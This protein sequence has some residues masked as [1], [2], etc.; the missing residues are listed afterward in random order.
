MLSKDGSIE[1]GFG[2]AIAFCGFITPLFEGGSIWQNMT[3]TGSLTVLV[4]GVVVAIYG[5]H[6]RRKS[7]RESVE[8]IRR[9]IA[10]HLE[11]STD[12]PRP[13]RT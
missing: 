6:L 4:T 1:I 10:E 12:S 5:R 11:H 2:L 7:Q 13:G 3:S 8:R 9:K